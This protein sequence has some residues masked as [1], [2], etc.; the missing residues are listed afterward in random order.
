MWTILI[1]L[2]Y[3]NENGIYRLGMGVIEID[4]STCP[5]CPRLPMLFAPAF[6]LAQGARMLHG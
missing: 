3:K 2:F 1:T 6:F 4:L 5:S